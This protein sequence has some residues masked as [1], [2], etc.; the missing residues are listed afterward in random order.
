MYALVQMLDGTEE[1]IEVM[2]IAREGFIFAPPL[3]VSSRWG[4]LKYIGKSQDSFALYRQV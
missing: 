3:F 2:P 1:Q 4:T